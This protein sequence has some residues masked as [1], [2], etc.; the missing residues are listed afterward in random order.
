MPIGHFLGGVAAVIFDPGTDRYLFLKRSSQKDYGKDEW[1]CVTGR[2]DQGESFDDALHREVREETGGE[3]QAEFMLGTTHFY[4]GK[5]IPENELNGLLF[6]CT[7]VNPLELHI[8]TEHSE[9]RWATMEEALTFLPEVHWLR[10]ALPRAEM[11][12]YGLPAEVKAFFRQNGFNISD[13]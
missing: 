1:E 2:V 11:L 9:M 13:P 4:R 7:V 12:R 6:G 5:E 3:I 8:S 10:K